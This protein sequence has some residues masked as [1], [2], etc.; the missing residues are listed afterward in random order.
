MNTEALITALIADVNFIEESRHYYLLVITLCWDLGLVKDLC[1][2][3]VKFPVIF[4]LS[5]NCNL[6]VFQSNRGQ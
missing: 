6:I 1:K 2:G 4:K 3:S 5:K